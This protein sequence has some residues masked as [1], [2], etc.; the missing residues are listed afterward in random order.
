VG[1]EDDFDSEHDSEK[2]SSSEGEAFPV[3]IFR[4]LGYE[5][6]VVWWQ[7]FGS[8]SILWHLGTYSWHS[9]QLLTQPKMKFI[10]SI[11]I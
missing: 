11:H 8:I 10:F 7:C 5:T 1:E 3:S 4:H 2:I 6:I 9:H